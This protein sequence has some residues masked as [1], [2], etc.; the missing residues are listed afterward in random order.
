MIKTSTYSGT[1]PH[2]NREMYRISSELLP[3]P[4]W[5]HTLMHLHL[6]TSLFICLQFTYVYSKWTFFLTTEPNSYLIDFSY[7]VS[8]A[9]QSCLCL[10]YFCL[11]VSYKVFYR[12]HEYQDWGE[13][14]NRINGNSTT[15]ATLRRMSP[16][17]YQITMR[18]AGCEFVRI[19]VMH[20]L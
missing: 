9:S 8:S 2:I 3:T 10:S 14:S 15:T 19:S 20:I 4:T 5:S 13:W 17:D 1:L 11:S 6:C 16:G 18:S 7:D 12:Q